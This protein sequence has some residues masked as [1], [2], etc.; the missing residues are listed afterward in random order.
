M[1]SSQEMHKRFVGKL[2]WKVFAWNTEKEMDLGGQTVWV[3]NWTTSQLVCPLSCFNL[4]VWVGNWTT[5]QL[6]WP[7]S[8]FNL[9]VSVLGFSCRTALKP[10]VDLCQVILI[11]IYFL[12]F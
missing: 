11:Q 3:G 9:T 5:S 12:S 1:I 7:L 6:V 2:P 10:Y 4:T 8:C